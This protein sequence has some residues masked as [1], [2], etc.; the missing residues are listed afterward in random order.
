M[1]QKTFEC[2]GTVFTFQIADDISEGQAEHLCQHAFEILVDADNQFSLYKPESEISQ[3][4][5]GALPWQKA[6]GV[7]R[8]V[9][10]QTEAWKEIT[11]GYFNAVSPEGKYD[12]SGLV[13]SWA[14]NNAFRFLEANGIRICT[15]NAGGDVLLGP[16][17]GSAP[18][19][20][21]GLAN[22]RPIGSSDAGANI[23]LELAHSEFRAV[24]TSGSVE[25]GEHIW[26]KN[27][28]REFVQATVISRDLV[29]AD[30][31]ATAIISGGHQAIELFDDQVSSTDAVAFAVTNK[32]AVIA[33]EG[34]SGLLATL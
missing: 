4:V 7:Q 2:M 23:I 13:K 28:K 30:I 6:S 16:D 34:F 9:R 22:L 17:V 32:G 27:E 1:F 24:A 31:W 10:T 11:G 21:V 20:R 29:T 25:R 3:I 12:P 15:L 8:D 18:L 5:S 26:Y 19:S 33:T 14:A